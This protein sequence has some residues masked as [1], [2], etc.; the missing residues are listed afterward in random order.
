MTLDHIQQGPEICQLQHEGAGKWISLETTAGLVNTVT[1]AL[2]DP[3]PQ[4]PAKP[5]LD[6]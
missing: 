4:G 3:Q 5:P 6:F 1:A 2:V